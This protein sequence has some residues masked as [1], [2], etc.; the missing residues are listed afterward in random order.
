MLLRLHKIN[1][2][3]VKI[4]S[5]KSTD[6][7][8]ETETERTEKDE[9]VNQKNKRIHAQK[10]Q[11][12]FIMKKTAKRRNLAQRAIVKFN[13]AENGKMLID[14]DTDTTVCSATRLTESIQE[15]I[16]LNTIQRSL[17]ANKA[18]QVKRQIANKEKRAKRVIDQR[19]KKATARVTA[20]RR[21][22]NKAKRAIDH[23]VRKKIVNKAKRAKKVIDQA[24]RNKNVN[25]AKKPE[26]ID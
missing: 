13:M 19:V 3:K 15:S 17:T 25:Q 5:R 8:T 20:K 12:P 1:H 14:G 22:A 7:D 16:A 9:Q 4:K 26:K 11:N 24:L 21:T 6:A 23:R 18:K 10:S 2:A